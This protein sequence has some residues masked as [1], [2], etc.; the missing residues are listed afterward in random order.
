MGTEIGA[1]N[2]GDA[3]GYNLLPAVA[4]RLGTCPYRPSQSDQ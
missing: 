4:A 2:F 1:R 3:D